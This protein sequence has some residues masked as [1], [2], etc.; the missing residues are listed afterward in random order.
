[1]QPNNN[2]GGDLSSVKPAGGIKYGTPPASV[3]ATQPLPAYVQAAQ[4][5]PA[6]VQGAQPAPVYAQG[7]QAINVQAVE[8]RT[9]D[10]AD[11]M[12]ATACCSVVCPLVGC[13]GL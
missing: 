13:I 2:I 3:P 6:Y 7:A 8:L 4:P 1:M 10:D 5:P 9:T 11:C 12:Y